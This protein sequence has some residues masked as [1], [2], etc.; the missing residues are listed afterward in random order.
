MT[1]TFDAWLNA[2][3]ASRGIRSARRLGMEAGLDPDKVADWVLGS[4]MPSDEECE[5]LAKYLGVE[6]REVQ[7]RRFPH[8]RNAPQG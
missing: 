7:E 2:E 1:G 3:M 8:R 6:A 4:S 5:V